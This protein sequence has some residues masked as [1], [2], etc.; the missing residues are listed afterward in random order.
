MPF[1]HTL[2]VYQK[3][4]PEEIVER[5]KSATIVIANVCEIM[6]EH[7][8]QAPHLQLLLILATGM[9]WVDKAYFAK[10]GIT[11]MNNPGANI[12]A[13]TEHFLGLYFASRKRMSMVDNLVK[14]THEW[15][16]RNSLAKIAWPQGPTLG[17]KQEVLGIIGY[18]AIG[19]RIEHL[20]RVLEFN[21]ILIAE[22]KGAE[23][24]RPGRVAFEE[25]LECATTVVC[26]C[27]RD[28]DTLNL[29]D[30]A[31]LRQM[32]KDALLI[33]IGR[34]GIINEAALA[35]ALRENW[36]FGAATDVLDIEPNGPGGTPLLPDLSKGDEEIPNLLITAH[37][38]WF[39]QGTLE[40]IRNWSRESVQ[41]FVEGGTLDPKV[42]Q[43]IAV[44]KGKIWK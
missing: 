4:A 30:E 28:V 12:D 2:D 6:P 18:G 26:V 43:R 36:I 41:A 22:R 20:A 35:K 38:A 19:H 31:Q 33:N 29:I 9:G 44:H 40:N 25:V 21:T 42:S 5:I 27:P 11:V 34:G 15:Q 7:V 39:S 3:T 17:C 16:N 1:P 23:K 37:T 24:I 32:R 8:E 10:K 13:V 14:T